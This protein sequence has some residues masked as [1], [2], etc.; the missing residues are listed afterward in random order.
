MHHTSDNNLCHECCLGTP[1]SDT[2]A[3]RKAGER[4]SKH[5]FLHFPLHVIEFIEGALLKH[6]LHEHVRPELGMV[7]VHGVGLLLR[8]LVIHSIVHPQETTPPFSHPDILLR[9]CITW[10]E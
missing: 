8:H 9:I 7:N 1:D 2:E 5:T 4:D 6:L 10:E 3:H